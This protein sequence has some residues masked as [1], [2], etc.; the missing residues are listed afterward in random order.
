MYLAWLPILTYTMCLL[1][2][3]VA[4]REYANSQGPLGCI[5]LYLQLDLSLAAH[6]LN[7]CLQMAPTT[8]QNP[9]FPQPKYAYHWLQSPLLPVLIPSYRSECTS[10]DILALA[11]IENSL[12]ASKEL[13]VVN[14]VDPSGLSQRHVMPSWNWSHYT[15][16]HL[17]QPNQRSQHAPVCHHP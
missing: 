10:E 5:L 2:K 15:P 17:A 16:V 9:Q 6:S 12:M 8:T 11:D 14:A 4:K 7:M 13:R 3:P 1:W